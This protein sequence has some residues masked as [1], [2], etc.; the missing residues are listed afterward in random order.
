MTLIVTPG[1]SDSNSYATLTEANAYHETRLHNSAWT[2]ASD[3]TK[4]AALIWATRELDNNF[5]WEG[6]KAT[7]EQALEWP[8]FGVTDKN[9]YYVDDDTIPQRLKNAESELAFALIT[10][11]RTLD[12]CVKIKKAKAGSLSFEKSENRESILSREAVVQVQEFGHPCGAG[13]GSGSRVL[14]TCRV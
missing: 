2:S 1:G 12:N 11:D 4:E 14:S 8:R 9:G 13:T 5:C 7:E 6:I 3:A 10:K